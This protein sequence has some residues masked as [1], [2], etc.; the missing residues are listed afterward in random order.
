MTRSSLFSGLLIAL[1]GVGIS[2]SSVSAQS[3][4]IKGRIV[5]GGA[6]PKLSPVVAKG[7][8]A[9]K[10]AAVCAKEEIPNEGLV[11]DGSAVANVVVYLNSPTAKNP[12]LE[13]EIVSKAGVIEIDQKNCKFIPHV[14]AMHS[15]QK[16]VFKSSDPVNH[17]VRYSA[18]S[19]QPFNQILAPNSKTMPLTLVPE[20]RPLPL[21][22]DI[23]PWMKGFLMVFNHPFFVVTGADGSFEIKGIPAGSHKFVAWQES[24]GYITSGAAA[25]QAVTVTA[26]QTTDVG[27]IKIDVAKLRITK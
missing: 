5:L 21:A 10:D 25:G 18:F 13:A 17:N 11:T 6:G 20:R 7:D 22:C 2:G 15:K 26:G 14:S 19:N 9:V 12:E 8:S 1:V 24:S 16:L 27:D 3:G 23:H 4:S